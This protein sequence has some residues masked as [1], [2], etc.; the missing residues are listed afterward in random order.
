M[1]GCGLASSHSRLGPIS[2]CCDHGLEPLGSRKCSKFI[3]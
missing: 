2:G 3:D 1:G